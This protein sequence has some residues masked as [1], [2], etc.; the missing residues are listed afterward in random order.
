MGGI[1]ILHWGR[2]GAGPRLARDLASA[3]IRDG[4]ERVHVSYATDGELSGELESLPSP[5]FPVRT[6][7]SPAGLVLGLP[8]ALFASLRLRRFVRRY[9]IDV[10]VSPMFSIWQSIMLHVFLPRSAKYIATVHDAVPHPGD[11]NVITS[12]C[13]RFDQQRANLIVTMSDAV[14]DQLSQQDTP[15]VRSV[16]PVFEGAGIRTFPRVA[17]K[18]RAWRIGLF[19]RLRPYKGVEVLAEA[20]R[21]LQRRGYDVEGRLVGSG[22]QGMSDGIALAPLRL[23]ERWVPEDAVNRTVAEFDILALP[24]R[25]ASQSGVLAVALAEGV[26]VVVSPVGGLKQQVELSSA[27][28]VATDMDA[29]SFA[30]ALQV[31]LDH[32]THYT[33]ASQSG[34][35]ASEDKFSWTRVGAD[36]LVAVSQV[37]GRDAHG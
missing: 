26:P 23:E 9:R 35:E 18:G 28:L 2:T 15:I 16:H 36:Y 32:P 29:T 25:E 27:G 6:Y 11:E 30:D 37:R 22:F 1:L 19:G 5:G 21:T 33:R 10:V 3:L 14:A 4:R 20:I 24:Y 31:Y 17:P 34:L 12:L 8:R 7:R 13:M